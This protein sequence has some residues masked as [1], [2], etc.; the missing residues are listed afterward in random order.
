M[1]ENKLQ[2]ICRVETVP[3]ILLAILQVRNFAGTLTLEW[4]CKSSCIAIP[5]K[6]TQ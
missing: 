1:V 2:L 5:Y 3:R 4:S 6:E